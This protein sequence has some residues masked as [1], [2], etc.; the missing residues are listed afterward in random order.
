V[1][2]TRRRGLEALAECE[3]IKIWRNEIMDK[4]FRNINAEINV[5]IIV[6]VEEQRKEGGINMTYQQ[7]NKREHKKVGKRNRNKFILV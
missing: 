7:R 1:S 3:R 4:T 2:Y 6:S 5:T